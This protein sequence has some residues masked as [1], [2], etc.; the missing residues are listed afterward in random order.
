MTCEIA[1][2][3]LVTTR[4]NYSHWET[5]SKVLSKYV[6]K[7]YPNGCHWRESGSILFFNDQCN[8]VCL[9]SSDYRELCTLPGNLIN[10][11]TM[12]LKM[13]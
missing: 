8:G 6:G 5:E 1:A 12:L 11:M 2:V 3:D 13:F 7:H 4:S 9:T 10:C